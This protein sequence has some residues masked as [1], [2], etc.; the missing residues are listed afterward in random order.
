MKE[1]KNIEVRD[2]VGV[3][4]INNE[5][6]VLLGKRKGSHGSEAWAFPGGHTESG[7]TF[8]DCAKR[9][10]LEETGLRLETLNSGP[11]TRDFFEDLN[12]EY[13]THFIVAKYT[14]GNPEVREP[15]KCE[16]WHWIS[17]PDL[18]ELR[19]TL[20]KPIQSLLKLDLTFE[21]DFSRNSA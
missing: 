21:Q 11:V 10:T 9:E 19:D 18:V 1:T 3:I 7:E 6:K 16:S 14:E 5:G 20:F 17:W 4:I 2:G 15:D 8:I 13:V 12:V